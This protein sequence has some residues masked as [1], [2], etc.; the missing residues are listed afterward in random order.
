MSQFLDDPWI[1]HLL[2]TPVLIKRIKKFCVFID[3]LQ[4][5]FED[6][7]E[8]VEYPNNG[9]SENTKIVNTALKYGTL[10][11]YWLSSIGYHVNDCI[12]YNDT[13]VVYKDIYK[14]INPY[15]VIPYNEFQE[16]Y[17][18]V[19][20][21]SG[22]LNNLGLDYNIYKSDA[23]RIKLSEMEDYSHIIKMIS[24]YKSLHHTGWDYLIPS[25]NYWRT[26][27]KPNLNIINSL[28]VKVQESGVV[29]RS[30]L[31]YD[32]FIQPNHQLRVR[33]NDTQITMEKLPVGCDEDGFKAMLPLINQVRVGL[34]KLGS[35][36]YFI[37]LMKG[38]NISVEWGETYIYQSLRQCNN[39]NHFVFNGHQDNSDL[40]HSVVKLKKYARVQGDTK[41]I[42]ISAFFAYYKD[43]MKKQTEIDNSDD[44]DEEC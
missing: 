31:H 41:N 23:F 16:T 22:S 7:G 3:G 19:R 9:I 38:L 6:S 37:T 24:L 12:I 27:R 10:Y 18:S 44:T 11:L 13:Y 42:P 1:S 17:N 2:K 34:H 25:E 28:M 21:L 8:Y 5:S 4:V 30:V 33:C 40:Y 39:L 15:N 20:F 36:F 29:I 43:I 35:M 14:K 26:Y 32:I